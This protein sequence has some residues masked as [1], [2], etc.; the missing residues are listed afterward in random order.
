MSKSN[1]HTDLMLS[2]VI[3]I[4][5]LTPSTYI[6]KF[7]RNDFYFE[8]GQ[9]LSLGIKG[10]LQK[11]EYSIYSSE[12]D[13]FLAVLVK[14]VEDGD[15]SVKLK[16]LKPGE[17]I[18][19]EGPFGHFTLPEDRKNASVVFVA[20][21]TGISPCHSIIKSNNS[22]NYK[23]LHGTKWKSEAYDSSEY[24]AKNYLQCCSQER[25]SNFYGRVTDY[26]SKNYIDLNAEYFLCGNSNMIY[27]TFEILRNKGV[28]REQIHM[29]VYF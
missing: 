5:N 23:I 10:S 17:L 13:N 9:Y 12:S 2:K 14:E 29:E 16:R 18:E 15:L 20:T 24:I 1:T 26:L 21:G 19:I 7:E 27:D 8:P 28:P 11:R 3:G 22:L 25:G 4:K 6:L